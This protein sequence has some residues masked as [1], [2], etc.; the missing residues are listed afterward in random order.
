MPKYF[1]GERPLPFEQIKVDIEA[2]NAEMLQ[3][4]FSGRDRVSLC[5][6]LPGLEESCLGYLFNIEKSDGSFVLV[7]ITKK[8][9][10]TRDTLADLESLIRHSVGYGYDERV[11]Q[12]L[13]KLRDLDD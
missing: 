8:K 10:I 7:D 11:H 12:L 9:L 2:V 13:G 1:D 5:V 6:R 3:T 4:L